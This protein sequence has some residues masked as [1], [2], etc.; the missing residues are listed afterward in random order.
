MVLVSPRW[1]QQ[2]R[3]YGS[4]LISDSN[5]RQKP[6][7]LDI[8]VDSERLQREMVRYR[9]S[10]CKPE[11]SNENCVFIDYTVSSTGGRVVYH[12]YTSF[13]KGGRGKEPE[14]ASKIMA[15]RRELYIH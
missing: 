10:K 8:D 7:R 4:S 1:P 15:C 14:F 13:K 9:T 11:R 6:H 2:T 3:A 12:Y 5:F